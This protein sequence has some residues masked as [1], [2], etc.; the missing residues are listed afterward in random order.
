MEQNILL[1]PGVIRKVASYYDDRLTRERD[2]I[3]DTIRDIMEKLGGTVS[4]QHYENFEGVTPYT[5][6][7]VDFDGYGVALSIDKIEDDD[8][9]DYTVVLRDAED[10]YSIDRNLKD[11]TASEA[12][13]VLM[14]LEE[15]V[16]K[17]VASGKPVV[18]EYDPDYED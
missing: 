14:Q 18:T 5:F 15:T 17:I 2:E 13:F 10:N 7:D 16:E 9:G 4:F 12:L 6:F 1:S 3:V 8:E 11:F